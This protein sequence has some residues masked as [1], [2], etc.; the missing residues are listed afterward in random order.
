MLL[1]WTT[2]KANLE[3]AEWLKAHKDIVSTFN[4]LA[5]FPTGNYKQQT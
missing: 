1:F 5:F 2:L 4:R 3:I